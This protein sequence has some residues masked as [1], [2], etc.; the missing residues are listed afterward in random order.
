MHVTSPNGNLPTPYSTVHESC[1][2]FIEK[3]CNSLQYE[4]AFKNLH[5]QCLKM[6]NDFNQENLRLDEKYLKNKNN[7]KV[8]IQAFKYLGWSKNCNVNWMTSF[9]LYLYNSIPNFLFDPIYSGF[10][11]RK[12]LAY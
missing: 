3:F 11:K 6:E 5:I 9:K 8:S 4:Y 10:S 7:F 12:I 2:V 1:G